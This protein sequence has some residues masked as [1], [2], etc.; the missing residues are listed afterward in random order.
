M[1]FIV[2]I[3]KY[4]Y[5]FDPSNDQFTISGLPPNEGGLTAEQF[6]IVTNVTTNQLIYNFAGGSSNNGITVG[7]ES[8]GSQTFTLGFDCAAMSGSDK[9]QI[10]AQDSSDPSYSIITEPFDTVVLSYVSAGNG[11]G[12]VETIVYK[13]GGAAGTE[14]ATLTLS[15]DAEDNITQIIRG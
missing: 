2:G 12:E 9:L 1:K 11:E 4:S 13:V 10:I 7:G 6:L 5:T 3:D 15:Y 14:V 8:S